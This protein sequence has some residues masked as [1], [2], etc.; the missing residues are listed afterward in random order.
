MAEPEFI[1]DCEKLAALAQLPQ[2]PLRFHVFVCTGKSCSA[3]GSAEVKMA[4]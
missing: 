4:V 3:V 2:A 1:H